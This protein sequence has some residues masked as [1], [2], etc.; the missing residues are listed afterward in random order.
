MKHA[1]SQ[2]FAFFPRISLK[3]RLMHNW[4][5][6]F[7]KTIETLIKQGLGKIVEGFEYELN[8]QQLRLDLRW[9]PVFLKM[10]NCPARILELAEFEYLRAQVK[11]QDL[12]RPRL[13]EGLLAVNPSAQFM[14]VR[15]HLP[16]INRAPGLFCL[17]KE[18]GRSFEMELSLPQALLLDLLREDRKYTAE[19][20]L[21]QAQ[22]HEV[23]IPLSLQ[24]WRQTL[25]SLLET[26]VILQSE[27]SAHRLQPRL[28]PFSH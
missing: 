7:P 2:V 11:T 18:G 25:M 20:L 12:G 3:L 22:L 15:H 9:F 6:A 16:E 24:E 8:F 21:D 1:A 10:Q 4:Q 17:V 26:G 27:A 14:E 28:S 13:E 23:K 5:S 19:Q